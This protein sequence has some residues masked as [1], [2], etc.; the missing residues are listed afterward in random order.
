MMSAIIAM[1]MMAAMIV[2]TFAVGRGSTVVATTII[3]TLMMAAMI[4]ATLA[5]G[6]GSTVAATTIIA[7]LMMA[8]AIV[9]TPDLAPAATIITATREGS[10][11][12]DRC[13]T[14]LTHGIAGAKA[15]A[16]VVTHRARME[17]SATHAAPWPHRARAH[18]TADMTRTAG[19]TDAAGKQRYRS[20]D[21]GRS[22]P[23]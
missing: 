17:A 9:A 5:V 4:I 7:T 20:C 10:R 22:R 2:A 11:A 19:L 15:T 13:D 3:T 23:N 1:L 12:A 8:A 6:R 21:E 14:V 18:A 16:E